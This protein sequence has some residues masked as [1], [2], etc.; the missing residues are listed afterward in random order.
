MSDVV[1]IRL[2]VGTGFVGGDHEETIEVER[3]WWES[4]SEKRQEEYLNEVSLDYLH[5]CIEHNAWVIEE[6]E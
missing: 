2:H 1:R 6:G 4:L 5:E 3:S